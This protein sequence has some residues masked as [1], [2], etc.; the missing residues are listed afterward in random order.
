[1]VLHVK[2]RAV[3]SLMLDV[4]VRHGERVADADL[5]VH[6][7][8]VRFYKLGDGGLPRGG[9]RVE[10]LLRELGEHLRALRAD[11]EEEGLEELPLE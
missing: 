9:G 1:M 7:A 6:R 8:L 3:R 10:L 4:P 2:C 5:L 11:G